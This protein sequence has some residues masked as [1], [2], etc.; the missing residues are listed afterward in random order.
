MS[1]K[2]KL[3]ERLKQSGLATFMREKVK[4]IAGDVLEIVGDI[5]GVDAVERVGELLNKRKENDENVRALAAE[6]E[7]KRI[8]WAMEIER[9]R[10][11]VG[12][13]EMRLEVQDKQ[14]ARSRE[15]EYMKVSGGKRDWIQGSIA[16][17]TLAAT[18]YMIVFLSF[19]EVPKANERLF[20]MILGGLVVSSYI[21]IRE[22]YYGTSKGSARK[23][24]TI[25]NMLK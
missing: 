8:E 22:Y 5:T 11:E 3:I 25:R 10:M 4:P 19:F 9:T 13:E 1:D 16:I 17:F 24:E 15:I 20:D 12:L 6:F 18:A 7:E 23:D 21:S 14:D 2:P